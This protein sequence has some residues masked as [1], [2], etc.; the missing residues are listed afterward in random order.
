MNHKIITLLNRE[1]IK[2]I[3]RLYVRFSINPSIVFLKRAKRTSNQ[4]KY[5]S[6]K[7]QDNLNRKI[8]F[9]T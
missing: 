4:I 1:L 7:K 3:F 6:F 5:E 9:T 8:I 2:L